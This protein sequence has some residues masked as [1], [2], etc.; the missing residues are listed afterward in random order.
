MI[1]IGTNSK[2]I[3]IVN[4]TFENWGIN[5]DCAAIVLH[6]S[7]STAPEDV[8]I[9]T[10][11]FDGQS[12][13]EDGVRTASGSYI[14]RLDISHNIFEALND[15][16]WDLDGGV[17]DG[18]I[19]KDNMGDA[20]DENRDPFLLQELKFNGTDDDSS[21]AGN[22]AETYVGSAAPVMTSNYADFDGTDDQLDLN[23]TPDQIVGPAG[24]TIAMHF[25]ADVWPNTPGDVL[26]GNDI[27]GGDIFFIACYSFAG[28]DGTAEMR[29]Y[30]GDALMTTT[31][32][33]GSDDTWYHIAVVHDKT[34]ADSSN[35]FFL[36]KNGELLHQ[37][38]L[39]TP[40]YNSGVEVTMGGVGA[41]ND[42]NGWID[43]FQIIK[44]PL[45]AWEVRALYE[46]K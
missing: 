2:D 22:D 13:G 3:K 31:D 37:D 7:S 36:Y 18:L 17:I 10:C 11:S 29:I 21:G 32:F 6:G 15:L 46:P 34:I 43:N 25:N 41:A 33:D 4:D 24:W 23:L 44:R 26:V 16:E 40:D 39:A 14:D 9:S 28:G 8:T 19:I 12:A 1:A 38:E 35:D 20:W 42:F 27:A 45:A 5:G 30:V